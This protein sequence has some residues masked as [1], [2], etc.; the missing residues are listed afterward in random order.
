MP[1]RNVSHALDKTLLL[2]RALC[3][4]ASLSCTPWKSLGQASPGVFADANHPAGATGPLQSNNVWKVD[5]LTGALSIKIPMFDFLPSSGRGPHVPLALL[6]NSSAN[7]SL[8]SSGIQYDYGGGSNGMFYTG[9]ATLTDS[10]TDTDCVPDQPGAQYVLGGG[11]IG[12]ESLRAVEEDFYWSALQIP[13]FSNYREG[14]LFTG[15]WTTTGPAISFSDLLIPDQNYTV[16]N[17]NSLSAGTPIHLGDGCRILGPF[18]YVDENGGSHDLNIDSYANPQGNLPSTVA[19]APTYPSRNP[20]PPCQGEITAQ[21]FTVDGSSMLSSI[22]QTAALSGNYQPQIATTDI[23]PAITVTYPDG[24]VLLPGNV[25]EDTN[26]NTAT[27]AYDSIGR[28]LTI[29]GTALN[30]SVAPLPAPGSATF[31]MLG[32]TGLALTY[33]AQF[34]AVA[35]GS[36]TMPHPINWSSNSAGYPDISDTGWHG[37]ISTPDEYVVAQMGSPSSYPTSNTQIASL[38]LPDSN[39]YTFQYDPLYGMVSYIGFPTGGHVRFVWGIRAVGEMDVG[40][41]I[42]KSTLAV[43]DVYLSNDAGGEDHWVYSIPSLTGPTA[44]ST[45]TAPDGTSTQYTGA[46]FKYSSIAEYQAQSS[47]TWQE[48][49]RQMFDKKGNLIESAATS[50]STGVYPMYGGLPA[51]VATTLYDGPSPIQRQTSYTYDVWDNPIEVD[52]SDYYGCSGSPCP[53]PAAPPAGWLRKTFTTYQYQ[54]SSAWATA[55]IVNKPS[56]VLVTDG[57]GHPFSLVTY[58]YDEQAVTGST[59]LLNHDDTNYGPQ[60]TLPR[61]N[62]TS[63]NRC[64]TLLGTQAVTSATATS[65]CSLWSTTKHTY[66]LAGQIVSTT[67]PNENTTSYSYTDNYVGTS[68]SSATDGYPTKV[69]YPNSTTNKYSYYYNTGSVAAHTDM[70]SNTTSYTYAATSTGPS[71]PFNRVQKIT[72]PVTTDGVTNAAGSGTTTYT[73]T[74]TSGAWQIQEQHLLDGTGRTTSV[75]STYDQLGR[76]IKTDT[77]DP[78]G[79]IYVQISYDN[80]GRIYSKTNPY[81]S[82]TDPTYGSTTYTYDAISRK[83]IELEPDTNTLQWCYEDAVSSGQSNCHP[84]ASSKAGIWVD[85]ADETGRDWQ[86]VK[87]GLGRLAAAIEPSANASLIGG[88]PALETDYAYDILGNLLGVTQN[89]GSGD[90]ARLRTFTYDSLSRLTCASNPESSQNSC[91]SALGTIP[92]GVMSYSYDLNGNVQFRTDTRGVTVSY[93]YDPL[94]RL[95]SKSYLG[96]STATASSC[97]QYDQSSLAA[98]GANLVGHL[99]N[100]WTQAGSCPAPTTI[101]NLFASTVLSRRSLLAYDAMGRVLNMQQCTRSNCTG[102]GSYAPS[103]TYDLAGN[104]INH[105]N[106][107]TA[108]SG[109]LLFA[110]GYDGTGRLNSVINITAPQSPYSLFGLP[111]A[112]LATNCNA[113]STPAYSPAGGLM[114]ATFGST[115]SLLLSRS[116]DVRFRPNCETDTGNAAQNP[117]PGTVKLTISGT[118]QTQ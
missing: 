19:M 104:L 43:T 89:G 29:S 34:A 17:N 103:Y 11:I 100:A 16:A 55:H 31:Q 58:G 63:E 114:N 82:L 2:A 26:G 60:S 44:T 91:P 101:P 88:V 28:T 36:F 7:L 79:D 72:Y 85:S 93:A 117:T 94:N 20:S 59:G 97:Y 40:M 84:N 57:S 111:A 80:M 98:S 1:D 83:T 69:T 8:T 90:T 54:N 21:S 9:C 66:D 61:G 52:E 110:N 39:S 27:Q 37:A 51:Q 47:P 13:L 76:L 45:V 46:P 73:Y 18:T 32:A 12:D 71:D 74:D 105:S 41:F 23:N 116:Y 49:L 107:M 92:N 112:A 30:S 87:D 62:L 38:T 15:A 67:D 50:Y 99:A 25:L 68:P 42:Q 75:T 109:Y 106:G 33:T 77:A 48:T 24:K 22:A 65:A 78:S 108:G 95:L 96:G 113:A 14:Y 4:L 102:G 5:P 118:D 6:Y 81:R 70:N 53:T 64:I 115:A 56:Q 86:T 35:L 10:S 3:L